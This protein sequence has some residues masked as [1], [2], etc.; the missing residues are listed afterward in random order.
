MK[1]QQ[2]VLGT[3]LRM[4]GEIESKCRFLIVPRRE[5]RGGGIKTGN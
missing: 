4:R 2:S 5:R 1:R 3:R